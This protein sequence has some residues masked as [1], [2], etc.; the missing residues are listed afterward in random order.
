MPHILS[1]EFDMVTVSLKVH[2]EEDE[3]IDLH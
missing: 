3:C 2:I 1:L